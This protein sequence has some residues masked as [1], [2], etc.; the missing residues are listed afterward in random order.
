MQERILPCKENVDKRSGGTVKFQPFMFLGFLVLAVST[1][2]GQEQTELRK[3][4]TQLRH[5][6]DSL[7]ISHQADR[8]TQQDEVDE[9]EENL[10]RRL[11]ELEKKIDAVSRAT[12]PIV[13]NPRTTA[14]INFAAR[15]DSKRVYDPADPSKEVSNR[16]YLRTV[17]LELRNP[18]DP[19]AEA[20]AIISI[21][22]QAGKEF[23]IDAEEA[24]GLIKRLPLLEEAPLGLKMKIGKY[25]APIG[26]NNKIHL[27]DL[28]WTTRPLII[29]QY[30]GTEHGNFF[31]S[32]FN[33]TGIDLDFFLPNPIPK[34]TL[35]MNLGV[36]RAGELGLSG[37]VGGSQPAYVSHINFS[38][39]WENAHVLVLGLSAYEE[40]GAATTR[41]YGIDL[42]YKWA[43]L[44]E[45]ESH[46]FVAGGELLAARHTYTSPAVGESSSSPF[47]WYGY[48]QLQ[49][50]YWL[51]LGIRYD[52][53][54][55]PVNDQL[56]TR[57]LAAYASYYTTEF[58]RF[59]LGVEHRWSDLPIQNNI[60]SGVFE[61]NVVFGSHPTEPYWVNK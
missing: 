3:E 4:V 29:S 60:T 47:G 51:Y 9:R 41:L 23:A 10:D 27:H 39:D 45:R 7:K 38:K 49:T 42:T 55:D 50:S 52:W 2:A 57:S 21:E 24:Y 61:V 32:G 53:L 6:L 44:E 8:T 22:N 5:E 54:K 40:H 12:A 31:E 19:Y 17:E 14:F 33:P 48:M 25:R 30:L 36:V 18:V 26:V 16:P 28:P 1:A 46:S 37:G 11:Q 35:E 43:P 15:G 13:L 59:R 20:I 34:T 58:L 56:V